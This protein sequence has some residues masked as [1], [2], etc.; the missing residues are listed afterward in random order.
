[1]EKKKAIFNLEFVMN[2][3]SPPATSDLFKTST[4]TSTMT[5]MTNGDCVVKMG[6][7]ENDV[8]IHQ[9]LH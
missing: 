7:Y 9:Q 3:E 4:T 8:I 5:S 2:V 6:N 1:M